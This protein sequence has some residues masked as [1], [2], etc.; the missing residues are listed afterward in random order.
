MGGVGHDIAQLRAKWQGAIHRLPAVTMSVELCCIWWISPICVKCCAIPLPP[1][2]GSGRACTPMCV[3][4]QPGSHAL[5]CHAYAAARAHLF[6]LS[7][8]V[9]IARVRRLERG[10]CLHGQRRAASRLL[11]ALSSTTGRCVPIRVSS[12]SSSLSAH[13]WVLIS[14]RRHA[15]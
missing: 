13:R 10:Q 12:C 2:R 11:E 3:R 14:P 5:V 1:L 6:A 4:A 7:P 8:R 15:K 9:R